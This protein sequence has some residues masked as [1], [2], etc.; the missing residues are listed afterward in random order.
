MSKRPHTALTGLVIAALATG[1]TTGMAQPTGSAQTVSMAPTVASTPAKGAAGVARTATDTPRGPVTDEANA[2]HDCAEEAEEALFAGRTD[3][4]IA[5]Y[6]SAAR[7]PRCAGDRVRLA[8]AAARLARQSA[9]AG[10]LADKCA[11]YALYDA[12]LAADPPPASAVDA[13]AAR[14]EAATYCEALASLAAPADPAHG[15]AARSALIARATA[16]SEAEAL[17][18][19]ARS[20]AVAPPTAS[21]VALGVSGLALLGAGVAYVALGTAED[22]RQAAQASVGPATTAAARREARARFESADARARVAGWSAVGLAATGVI[23][24]AVG[25]VGLWSSDDGSHEALRLDEDRVAAA[26][27]ATDRRP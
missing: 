3:D 4:A 14:N 22:D 12:V 7:D 16:E 24:G 11:V 5:L 10:T 18:A 1:T 6:S 27:G 19:F 21:Y 20:E 8:L 17:P 13:R 26:W 23:V 25:V 15:A 2:E 9:E